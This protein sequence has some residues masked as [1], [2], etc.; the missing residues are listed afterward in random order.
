M[1]SGIVELDDAYF[2]AGEDNGKRGRGT[3]KTKV[4]AGV[5]LDEAGRPQFA[6]ME[7]V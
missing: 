3:T 2:G 1:L 6:K 5:S 4:V 7:V